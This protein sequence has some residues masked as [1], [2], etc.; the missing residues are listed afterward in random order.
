MRLA[1]RT[2]AMLLQT[3]AAEP[4]IPG[5]LVSPP[6]SLTPG[7]PGLPAAGGGK[8]PQEEADDDEDEEEEWEMVDMEMEVDVYFAED[9]SDVITLPCVLR[10]LPSNACRGEQ[11]GALLTGS[12]GDHGWKS[13]CTT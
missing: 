2:P 12:P 3:C 10:S 5:C 8:R 13:G 1:V 7:E 6:A 9:V 4:K 11:N